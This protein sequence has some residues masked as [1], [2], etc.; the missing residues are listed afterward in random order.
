MSTK[1]DN[2]ITGFTDDEFDLVNWGEPEDMGKF[3]NI[4]KLGKVVDRSGKMLANIT[5][6][7]M[8][9]NSSGQDWREIVQAMVN[10]GADLD[11]PV[12]NYYGRTTTAREIANKYRGGV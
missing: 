9:I 5:P 4:N 2:R 1:N 11:M 10:A 8:V 6:L 3:S 12:E 7:I